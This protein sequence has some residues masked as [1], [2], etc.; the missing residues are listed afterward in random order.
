MFKFSLK[1]Y[2]YSKDFEQN[3]VDR[4]YVIRIFY[5]LRRFLVHFTLIYQKF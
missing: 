3:V 2:T 1:C 4:I 5:K